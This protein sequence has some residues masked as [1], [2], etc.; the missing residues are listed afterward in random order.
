MAT[1]HSAPPPRVS[2]NLIE[3]D[4]EAGLFGGL[5]YN[6][7]PLHYYNEILNFDGPPVRVD[8]DSELAGLFG[9]GGG[10]VF[11]VERALRGG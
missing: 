5:L 6:A 3:F 7:T 8:L 10:R 11:G 9:G 4:D 1:P 2:Q